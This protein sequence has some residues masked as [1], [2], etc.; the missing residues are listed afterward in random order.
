M[1]LAGKLGCPGLSISSHTQAQG[2]ELSPLFSALTSVFNL[3]HTTARVGRLRTWVSFHVETPR[4]SMFGSFDHISHAPKLR[5]GH[6][7]PVSSSQSPLRA[8]LR[9]EVDRGTYDDP[10]LGNPRL[11]RRGG[12]SHWQRKA[13]TRRV[14]GKNETP[15]Q[16]HWLIVVLHGR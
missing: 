7:W 4:R 12:Q 1:L 8:G 2:L 14:E 9:V 3:H 11:K 13:R 5:I 10:A 6:L 16:R 15:V